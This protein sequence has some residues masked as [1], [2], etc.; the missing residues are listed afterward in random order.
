LSTGT[1]PEIQGSACPGLNNEALEFAFPGGPPN[2]SG[3]SLSVGDS[4]A[5]TLVKQNAIRKSEQQTAPFAAW[6]VARIVGVYLR[7]SQQVKCV[8]T[9][10]CHVQTA[11]I[12]QGGEK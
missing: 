4:R 12:L 3:F 10:D 8:E 5:H 6:R 1:W 9:N 7:K 11:D 2:P